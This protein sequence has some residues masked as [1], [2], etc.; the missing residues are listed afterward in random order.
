MNRLGG[1][2]RG[3]IGSGVSRPCQSSWLCTV[4][5]ENDYCKVCSWE[6]CSLTLM[7]ELCYKTNTL[8]W[9]SLQQRIAGIFL[10]QTPVTHIFFSFSMPIFSNLHVS[11]TFLLCSE[12]WMS[13]VS[14]SHTQNLIGKLLNYHRSSPSVK[15]S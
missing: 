2:G 9:D 7:E 12:R 4:K 5:G 8:L 14:D 6:N 11:G 10:S 3:R 15:L 13:S 1:G